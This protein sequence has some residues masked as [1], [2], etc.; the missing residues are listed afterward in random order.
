MKKILVVDNHKSI[1]DVMETILI[2]QG[3][4]VVTASSYKT[5]LPN[6]YK[7]QPDIIILD[8]MLNNE[9]GRIICQQLKENNRT[10]N[11]CIIL[12]SGSSYKL[13][14]Y[15]NYNADGFLEKPFNLEDLLEVLEVCKKSSEKIKVLKNNGE[16]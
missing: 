9:D 1:L 3:Y 4:E 6:I 14:D 5:I 15:K 16:K 8:V 2:Q 11:I 7:N 12:F 10:K 13:K